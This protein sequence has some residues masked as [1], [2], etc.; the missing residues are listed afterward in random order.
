MLATAATCR[1]DHTGLRRLWRHWDVV[2]YVVALF[3]MSGKIGHALNP[4][5]WDPW[6]IRVERA[7]GGLALLQWV[8]TWANRPLDELGKILWVSYYFLALAPGLPLYWRARPGGDGGAAFREAKLAIALGYVL[9][10]LGYLFTPALGPLHFK[11]ELGLTDPTTGVLVAGALKKA[12]TALHG[13]TARYAFPSGHALTTAVYGWCLV[14]HRVRPLVWFALPWF[15]G[16]ILSTLYLRYHYLSDVI[17]GLALAAVACA[18]ATHWH[19]RYA[20]GTGA[21]TA[22]PRLLDSGDVDS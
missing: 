18:A 12:V 2:V 3:L 7:G 22:L 6:L 9:S 5:D 20:R 10:F 17:A 11:A 19:A 4:R 14:R 8:Q 16:V 15:G 13:T 1:Y 21:A